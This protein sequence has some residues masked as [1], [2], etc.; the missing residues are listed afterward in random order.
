VASGLCARSVRHTD[1]TLQGGRP[2][3]AAVEGGEGQLKRLCRCHLPGAVAREVVS[4]LPY[5]ILERPDWQELDVEV[6]Q[7]LL[8]GESLRGSLVDRAGR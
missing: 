5:S 7:I 6:R 1:L 2:G 4:Q 3:D 8:A